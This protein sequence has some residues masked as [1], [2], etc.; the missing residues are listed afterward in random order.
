MVTRSMGALDLRD[1]LR[2]PVS[3]VA[4]GYDRH[5][6]AVRDTGVVAAFESDVIGLQPDLAATFPRER[7]PGL[8]LDDVPGVPVACAAP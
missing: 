3:R 2:E 1:L 7:P 4:Q 8:G 5:D 6:C